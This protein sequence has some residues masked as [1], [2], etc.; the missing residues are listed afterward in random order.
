M[1]EDPHTSRMVGN[2]LPC[3]CGESSDGLTM[4]DDGHSYCHVCRKDFQPE[5]KVEPKT[6]APIDHVEWSPT[7]WRDDLIG[8]YRNIRPET[9]K[10]YRTSRVTRADGKTEIVYPYQFGELVRLDEDK[11]FWSRGNM[12]PGQ[13]FGMGLFPP[14]SAKA[15][16]IHEGANDAMS[17]Y[18]MFGQ[19]YPNVSV[20]SSSSAMVDCQAN[21]DYLNSFEKIYIAMDPDEPGEA[22]ARAIAS[23]FDFDK[24]Y[25]VRYGEVADRKDAND[26]LKAGDEETYRKLWF[27]ARKYMP[28]CLISSWDEIE[29]IIRSSEPKKGFPYPFP[30]LTEMTY[31][32]KPGEVVLVTAME[33]V[34]KTEFVR[35]IEEKFLEEAPIEDKIGIIHLEEDKERTVQGLVGLKLGRP[36]HLPDNPISK[37]EMVEAFKQLSKRPDRTVIYDHFGSDDPQVLYQIVQ[38]LVGPGQCKLIVLDHLSIVVSGSIMDDERKTL[39]WL[40]TRIKMLAKQHGAAFVVISHVNDDGKPRGSRNI[41]KV[42]DTHIQLTR[43]TMSPV[44][45]VKSLLKTSIVK[46]RPASKTGPADDIR[47][48]MATTRLQ[49]VEVP[50]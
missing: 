16:T 15:I 26:F 43:D 29:G 10:F 45:E 17:G 9:L 22:A 7:P 12:R 40:S 2:H 27:N 14:G 25:H 6:T 20:K 32:I 39:D 35:A 34:G 49:A 42:C 38:F 30:R 5:T 37:D 3:P 47:Y 48:D 8:R 41:A 19:Q 33:G 36:A 31:G 23:L 28:D 1:F 4:Y 18:D 44:E 21:Y 11:Q 13:L 46:N 24:V 50:F